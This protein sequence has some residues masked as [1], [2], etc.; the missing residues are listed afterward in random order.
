[1]AKGR[2]QGST[3]MQ[4]A[5]EYTKSILFAIVLA[6]GIRSTLVQA[7]HIPSGSMEDTLLEG[8]YVLGLK[9]TFGTQIPDRLPLLNVKLPSF[10]MPGYRNPEPGDLVIFEFPSDPS[11]DFIKRCIAVEGQT[12]EIRNK[13]LIVDGQPFEDPPGVKRTNPH[14]LPRR[15]SARDNF[16]PQ[17]VP[18]GHIFVMGDN[19]DNSSDSRFWGPVPLG[20]IKAHPLL[21]YFSVDGT[22]PLWNPIRKIRWGRLGTVD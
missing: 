4:I 16:G 21:I 7:Y 10:E 5:L 3:G 12:V 17:A 6:V 18:P 15:L 11:R 1:M 2:M 19:R 9:L 20:K 8:D 22:A 14:A 13:A